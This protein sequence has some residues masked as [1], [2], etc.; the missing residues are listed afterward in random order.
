[1]DIQGYYYLGKILKAVGVR[2]ELMVYLDV[3]DP[4][5]YQNLDAVFVFVGGNL[6]PFMVKEINL[7][8]G[9]QA[10]IRLQ[11]IDDVEQTDVLTGAGLYLPLSALPPLTERQF[12][13]HEIEG[14]MIIDQ[15]FGSLG[16]VEKVLA[17]P[18]QA[19]LQVMHKDKE[20][21][22]PVADEIILK[23][24]KQL[25]TIH[26]HAPEGLIEMYLE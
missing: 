26:I 15:K 11:D 17:Y 23:V 9:K 14:F 16:K 1:M 5:K 12:Y 21:L 19:L 25:K 22:I 13:Y 24:D 20:V 7:R 2:G 3:D 4:E 8:T 18:M 10:L 6:V